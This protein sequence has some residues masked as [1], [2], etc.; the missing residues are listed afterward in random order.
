MANAYVQQ[1]AVQSTSSVSSLTTSAMTVTAG[2]AIASATCANGD[3]ST[4]P[5]LATTDSK[6]DVYLIQVTR[7]EEVFMIVQWEIAT[8]IVGGSTTF[9]VTPSYARFV[10]IVAHEYSGVALAPI[11]GVAQ[12]WS[13]GSQLPNPGPLA[14]V[15]AGDL[16]LSAWTHGGGIN[17]T[18]TPNTGWTLRGNLTP[19]ANMPLG[20]E[21][22]IGSGTQTGS[23][24]L[25]GAGAP[26]WAC[27]AMALRAADVAAPDNGNNP[28]FVFT[29]FPMA[30]RGF[31]EF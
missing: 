20:T 24:T 30:D 21:E 10:S 3:G 18:F 2:N 28:N 4:V 6:S 27:A 31:G 15:S 1:K 11:E 7:D 16:F 22:L 9:T 26:A 17:E 14:P 19:T 5:S 8:N 29:D 12:G 23:A 25:S 13:F